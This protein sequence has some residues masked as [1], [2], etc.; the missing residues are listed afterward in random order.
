MPTLLLL[1]LKLNAETADFGSA[2]SLG[3]L[4]VVATAQAAK[5]ENIAFSFVYM[6]TIFQLIP[7]LEVTIQVIA[8][9]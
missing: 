2:S 6:R 1:L 8:I 4:L 3:C 5:T 7:P 9:L